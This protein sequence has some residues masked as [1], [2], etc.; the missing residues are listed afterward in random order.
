M[1]V[2]QSTLPRR[3]RPVQHSLYQ[4]ESSISI[5]APA[6]G[7]TK[8]GHRIV[9]GHP[10]SIHAPAK[11]ATTLYAVFDRKVKISIHAPAKGATER[12]GNDPAKYFISIHA[13]AKGATV[14]K[15][16]Y[17]PS[18]EISIHAPA[19]GATRRY[20]MARMKSVIFQSTLPRRERPYNLIWNEW[21]RDI[22]IHAPAK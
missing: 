19:K 7:A 10:I 18:A 11:G 12:F 2:F 6:K 4:L 1:V 21:F 22:S 8:S 15:K 9:F 14:T 17:G 3:E 20:K 5:H 16:V 13:P